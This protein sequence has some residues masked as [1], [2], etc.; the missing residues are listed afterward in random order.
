[1]TRD[2]LI[3]SSR[4]IRFATRFVPCD[5]CTRGSVADGLELSIAA[6]HGRPF[7]KPN[8][9]VADVALKLQRQ[10][11]MLLMDGDPKKPPSRLASGEP[12]PKLAEESSSAPFRFIQTAPLRDYRN[13][14]MLRYGVHHLGGTAALQTWRMCERACVTCRRHSHTCRSHSLALD[15]PKQKGR[16][17]FPAA[18]WTDEDAE[19]GL[20]MRGRCRQQPGVLGRRL[21]PISIPATGLSSLSQANQDCRPVAR[22]FNAIDSGSTPEGA[23]S[24]GPTELT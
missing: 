16:L 7:L 22:T 10:R 6:N 3:Q 15:M 18:R 4:E 1:M 5:R 14:G 2:G 19:P 11:G 17:Q 12:A 20:G 8:P 13:N 21:L 9:C 24:F 23:T